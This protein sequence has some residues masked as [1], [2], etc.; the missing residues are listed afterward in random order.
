MLDLEW[1]A[2]AVADLMAIVD[3]IS[4]DNSDA[5]QA[6]K[7]DDAVRSSARPHASSGTVIAS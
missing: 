1:K 7:D 6:L 4:D 3:Y 2:T 5:A